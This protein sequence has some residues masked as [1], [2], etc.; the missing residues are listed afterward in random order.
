[1]AE[2][3]SSSKEQ[4]V[5]VEQVNVG[6]HQIDNLTQQNAANTEASA[7][8]A[9]EL[10]SQAVE[11]QRL[12]SSFQLRPEQTNSMQTIAMQ[13][14]SPRQGS[15]RDF[16]KVHGE[17]SDKQQPHEQTLDSKEYGRY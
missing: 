4:A 12:I 2:I 7:A 14:H 1:V 16:N 8:A 9:E 15:N 5:G 3:V 11:L 17:E 6:L 13:K 10:S